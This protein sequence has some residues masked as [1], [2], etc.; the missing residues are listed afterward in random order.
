MGDLFTRLSQRAHGHRPTIAPRLPTRFE[1]SAEPAESDAA[2]GID[3]AADGPTIPAQP[4]DGAGVAIP[5]PPG[6]RVDTP[7][8]GVGQ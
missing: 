1:S 3:S 4:A 5:P 6:V 7:A 2:P 8:G